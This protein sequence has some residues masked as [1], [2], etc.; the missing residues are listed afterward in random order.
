MIAFVTSLDFWRNTSALG[1]GL[2]LQTVEHA[3]M[4]E[5]PDWV[6]AEVVQNFLIIL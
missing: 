2:H 6:M 5:L 4:K 1:S 3:C